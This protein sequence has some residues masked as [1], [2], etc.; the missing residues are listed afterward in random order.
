[1]FLGNKSR[2]AD[3][4]CNSVVFLQNEL[5]FLRILHRIHVVARRDF[6]SVCFSFVKI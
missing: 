6:F 3:L 5:K 2:K 1:M 4:Q